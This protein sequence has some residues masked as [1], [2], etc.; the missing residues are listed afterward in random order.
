MEV[1][2]FKSNSRHNDYDL[3]MCPDMG[4][5]L[6]NY[7]PLPTN[8]SRRSKL[9]TVRKS[10][11]L[12]NNEIFSNHVNVNDSLSNK[13]KQIEEILSQKNLI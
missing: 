12:K 6:S 1:S 4:I 5:K 8:R 10:K 3:Q 9:H 2:Q 7:Q 11:A 13:R